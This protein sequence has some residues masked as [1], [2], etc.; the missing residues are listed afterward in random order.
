M[1]AALDVCGSR[2][3]HERGQLVEAEALSARPLR[4]QERAGRIL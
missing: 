3:L 1:S 2:P 4:V